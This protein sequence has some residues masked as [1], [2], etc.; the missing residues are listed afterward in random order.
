MVVMSFPVS[1]PTKYDQA[2]AEKVLNWH[3]Y[4]PIAVNPHISR[5]VMAQVNWYDE[6]GDPTGASVNASFRTWRWA[7]VLMERLAARGLVCQL[8]VDPKRDRFQYVAVFHN[9]VRDDFAAGRGNTGPEA[10]C[11]GA[12]RLYGLVPSDYEAEGSD[13][14]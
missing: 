3:P 13:V 2:I 5:H 7:G 12:M 11:D 14:A 8:T 6:R 10:I 1:E 4:D 9:E